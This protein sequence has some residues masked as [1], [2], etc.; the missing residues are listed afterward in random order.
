MEFRINLG[1]PSLPT[2][3]YLCT[4]VYLSLSLIYLAHPFLLSLWVIII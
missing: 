1:S 3:L 2:V 4:Y